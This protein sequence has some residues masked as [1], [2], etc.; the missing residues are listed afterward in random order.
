MGI[1]ELKTTWGNPVK[2]YDMERTLCDMVKDKNCLLYTSRGF[3]PAHQLHLPHGPERNQPGV[4]KQDADPGSGCIP[5]ALRL[6]GRRRRPVQG[7]RGICI[8]PEGP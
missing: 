1:T 8:A 6:R 4:E 2:V 7:L 3:L 5:T